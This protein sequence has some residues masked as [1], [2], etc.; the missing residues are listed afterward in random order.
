MDIAAFGS[1]FYTIFLG[2]LAF[3]G[4]YGL[5]IFVSKRRVTKNVADESSKDLGLRPLQAVALTTFIYF[6]GFFISQIIAGLVL[7]GHVAISR[8]TEVEADALLTSAAV[9]AAFS[10][11]FYGAMC[12]FVI[13]FLRL[14]GLNLR[15]IGLLKPRPRDLGFA[16]IAMGVYLFV[17]TIVTALVNNFAPF[18]DLDQKQEL[19]F[20]SINTAPELLLVFVSLVVVPPLVE[21]LMTRG[22]LFT[23]LRQK[24]RFAWT[25]IITSI[26]FAI[27]H[28]QLGS[29]NP[30][31]WNA[32][33]DTFILSL[34][35][36]Y[37]RERT[38]S[39][40]A[41]I[42]MHAIKNGIA[43]TALFIFHVV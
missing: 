23:G 15:A 34:F 5:V 39:L 21:E 27:P 17:A 30:P 3:F 26:V 43:F 10:A 31:L 25:V 24:V 11:L 4:V 2:A 20:E 28:L 14:R 16:L 32:A 38:G 29:G 1:N 41:S 37:L 9:Q 18:L 12:L 35:L 19:G 40:W 7:G 33:L 36:C 8:L 22:L 6:A 42:F 13:W